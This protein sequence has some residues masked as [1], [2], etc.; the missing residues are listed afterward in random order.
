MFLTR[1]P[2]LHRTK[3]KRAVPSLSRGSRAH[4]GPHFF[5]FLKKKKQTNKQ[6]K[7]R[8]GVLTI[9]H[10]R[11]SEKKKTPNTGAAA[12]KTTRINGTC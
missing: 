7:L 10:G 3:Q 5:I 6:T 9:G 8:D 2:R 12:W 4:P 11:M 1:E